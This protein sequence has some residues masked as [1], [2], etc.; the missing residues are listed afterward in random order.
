MNS[1]I[2]ENGGLIE[3][4]N[5][6]L[7]GKEDLF[8]GITLSTADEQWSSASEFGQRLQDSLEH[9]KSL[10]KRGVWLKIAIQHSE[11]IPEAV[12]NQ[13]VFHH[14]QPLYVMMTAWLPSN[15]PNQLPGYAS[16]YIGVGG[17]VT[18]DKNEL[19][20]IKEKYTYGR[21]A[22]WKL[23]GGHADLDEELAAT[24]KREVK[25][26]TGID[27]EFV[28]IV[29][30]RHQHKYKFNQSDI[31]FV[32]HMRALTNEI[33]TCP[34]EIAEC[35]WMNL[36]EYLVDPDVTNF[37]KEITKRYLQNQK[38]NQSIQPDQLWSTF[39]NAYQ[40]MYSIHAGK[41]D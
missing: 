16:N 27:A 7:C 21:R 22:I 11:L 36:D 18:N 9:W 38:S 1:N 41:A 29:C 30:F 35:R 3:N 39:S 15:E 25:E 8:D 24:A 26:E 6:L 37:N 23:P 5:H 20:V 40:L 13:F 12:K 17:F 10:N 19:L 33:K 4:A 32:C 28:S 2:V 14:A 31:Y 34:H